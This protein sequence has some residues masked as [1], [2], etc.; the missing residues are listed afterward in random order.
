MSKEQIT[1]P[2]DFSLLY[3]TLDIIIYYC[4]IILT[5]YP[6]GPNLT[7]ANTVIEL[8]YVERPRLPT[9]TCFVSCV[10]YRNYNIILEPFACC[11]YRAVLCILHHVLVQGKI[12]ELWNS[13]FSW[14]YLASQSGD[15]LF[16]GTKRMDLTGSKRGRDGG[17]LKAAGG[18]GGGKRR[19][20]RFAEASADTLVPAPATSTPAAPPPVDDVGCS[21]TVLQYP[22]AN[23]EI[24]IVVLEPYHIPVLYVIHVSSA[25]LLGAGEILGT[26][27][28][29]GI[30]VNMSWL[31]GFYF[32]LMAYLDSQ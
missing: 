4:R 29:G 12:T 13:P 24:P 2:P 5:Q 15:L 14:G 27:S 28:A 32:E 31:P 30:P 1:L 11:T 9:I 10:P 19:R 16:C 25:A 20:N 22:N 26:Q 3:G 7:S 23:T 21:S 17:D 8:Q 6:G 18:G